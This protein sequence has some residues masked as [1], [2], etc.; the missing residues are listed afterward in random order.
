MEKKIMHPV[1]E[2][3]GE[4]LRATPFVAAF[5]ENPA[6]CDRLANVVA[7]IKANYLTDA[8]WRFRMHEASLTFQQ[9]RKKHYAVKI[10]ID[11]NNEL[12]RK[13][14]VAIRRNPIVVGIELTHVNPFVRESI[15]D[16]LAEQFGDYYL[17]PRR[18]RTDSLEIIS[19]DKYWIAPHNNHFYDIVFVQEGK[20]PA[21]APAD[22]VEYYKKR[23]ISLS[24]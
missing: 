19:N 1:K 2:K 20:F 24:R 14:G 18:S 9:F 11:I 21:K 7:A 13:T 10:F 8:G 22:M 17:D 12:A 15:R 5:E 3:R 4:P 6:M 16:R 23:I